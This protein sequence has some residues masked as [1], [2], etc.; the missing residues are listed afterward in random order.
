MLPLFRRRLVDISR[1]RDISPPAAH[2]V[3]IGFRLEMAPCRFYFIISSY[4]HYLFGHK[5]RLHDGITSHGLLASISLIASDCYIWVQISFRSPLYRHGKPRSLRH[6]YRVREAGRVTGCH[7]IFRQDSVLHI[8]N[9]GVAEYYYHYFVNDVTMVTIVWAQLPVVTGQPFL[10]ITSL[11]FY[12]IY[13]N[14]MALPERHT[15][16]TATRLTLLHA[17]AKFL[18]APTRWAYF[19]FTLGIFIYSKS[20]ITYSLCQFTIRQRDAI[21]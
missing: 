2:D 11:T 15:C 4:H 12:Y 5:I 16:L 9:T 20:Q 3:I 10:P 18:P 13:K 21:S 19:L 8:H 7:A 6:H 1:C 17:S 14:T